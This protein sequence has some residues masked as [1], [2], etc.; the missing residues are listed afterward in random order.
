MRR[1]L[2]DTNVIVSAL[3]F[4]GSTPAR[5]LSMVM[6]REHLVLSDWILDELREV[7]ERKWPGRLSVLET[8]ITAIGFEVLPVGAPG[9]VMRDAADQPIL[10]AAIAGAVD[11]IV[12]GDKDFLA[13]AI[14]RPLILT[15]REYVDSVEAG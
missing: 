15:A 14:D 10:D 1:V 13:L 4:P 3:I 8:F 5:A 12:T 6:E 9:V 11:V 7:V 2:V